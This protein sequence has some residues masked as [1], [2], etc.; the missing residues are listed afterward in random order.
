MNAASLVCYIQQQLQ[1]LVIVPLVFHFIATLVW[2]VDDVLIA[3][4]METLSSRV[5]IVQSLGK[6]VHWV[7]V[8]I[9]ARTCAAITHPVTE[10]LGVLP[11]K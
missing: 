10:I 2:N 5:S 9:F 8:N 6:Y 11:T 7:N 3:H 1:V 4:L